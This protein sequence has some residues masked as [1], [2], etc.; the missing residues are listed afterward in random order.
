MI[1]APGVNIKRSPL[2][3]RN[4]E[5]FSEDPYLTKEL[6]VPYI[7]GVQLWDVAACVKHFAANNQE[8]E[9]LW[10]DVDIDENVL[11][12]IYLPAFHDAVTKG[13]ANWQE[14]SL[15]NGGGAT[16][17]AAEKTADKALEE[18]RKALREE[19][20]RQTHCSGAGMQ[21]SRAETRLRMYCLAM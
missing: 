12:E 18:K 13:D 10:V 15:E 17:E 5:Y 20:I 19:A 14:T 7:R 2:C 8:T 1:L 4:F 6:A 11:R 3:G 16:K 21:A 9:R